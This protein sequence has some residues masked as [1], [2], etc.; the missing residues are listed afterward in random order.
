M[1]A[2]EHHRPALLERTLDRRAD[3]DEHVPR[4]L[5]E[6]GDDRIVGLLGLAQSG[7]RLEARVVDRRHELLGEERAH[8]LPDEV[9]RRDPRDP[10]PVRGLRRDGRLARAGRA[11]DEDDHGQVELVQLTEAPEPADRLGALGVA[12]HLEGELLDPLEVRALLATLDEV[13]VDALRQLVRT[14]ERD[15]DRDEGAGHQALRVRMLGRA[16]RQGLGVAWMAHARAPAGT[17]RH[18]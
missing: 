15:A 14:S 6:A 18:D 16:E 8:R 3:A 2:L 12:E 10:E 11:A 7:R 4:L 5:E 13:L 17:S 9:G 1:D